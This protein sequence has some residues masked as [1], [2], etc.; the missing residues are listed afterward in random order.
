MQ[1]KDTTSF[2]IMQINCNSENKFGILEQSLYF[3]K[4]YIGIS[5]HNIILEILNKLLFFTN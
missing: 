5:N 3:F 1:R 4:I 2:L